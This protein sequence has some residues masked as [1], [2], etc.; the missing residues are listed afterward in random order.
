MELVE[1]AKVSRDGPKH[2]SQ[3]CSHHVDAPLFDDLRDAQSIRWVVRVS[4]PS[5]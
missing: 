5:R 4:L 1:A 2:V 3:L